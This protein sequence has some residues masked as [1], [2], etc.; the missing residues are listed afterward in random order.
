[1][2]ELLSI[3]KRMQTTAGSE[4][5]SNPPSHHAAEAG[6]GVLGTLGALAFGIGV[7]EAV[8]GRNHG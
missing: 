6:P 1:M 4:I 5:E 3:A 8:L 7:T 2:D